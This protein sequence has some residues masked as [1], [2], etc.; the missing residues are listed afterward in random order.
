MRTYLEQTPTFGPL[1][2]NE[3]ITHSSIR[4]SLDPF[5]PAFKQVLSPEELQSSIGHLNI[6]CPSILRN[7]DEKHPPPTELLTPYF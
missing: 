2:S 6:F 1:K 7:S 5:Y 3:E 4:R